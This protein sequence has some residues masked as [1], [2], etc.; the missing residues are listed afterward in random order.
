MLHRF[1]VELPEGTEEIGKCPICGN[2][3]IEG[4]KGVWPH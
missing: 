1:K 2:P 4:T 3:V